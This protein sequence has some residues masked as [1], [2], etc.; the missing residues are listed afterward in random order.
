M[1]GINET[2][3]SLER[4]IEDLKTRLATIADKLNGTH[5]PVNRRELLP[6]AP[7]TPSPSPSPSPPESSPLAWII[8]PL[9]S[10]SPQSLVSPIPQ[11]CA[12]YNSLVYQ[13]GQM[14]K[15]VKT[16]LKESDWDVLGDEREEIRVVPLGDVEKDMAV[17]V[18]LRRLACMG[19]K[20]S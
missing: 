14:Q 18:G 8:V 17:L 5:I 10:I 1:L 16:R 11:Y 2:I 4:N 6:T 9:L 20:V 3:K 15:T 12:T 13:W 7:R 19:V